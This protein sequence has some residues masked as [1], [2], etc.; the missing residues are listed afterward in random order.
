MFYIHQTSC[1]SP[2]QTFSSV[3]LDSLEEPIDK[4]MQALEPPYSDIPPGVLR[5]M[6]KVVRM[7]V[8]TAMPLLQKNKSVEGIIIGTA[9]GGKEDCVKFLNQIKEYDEGMLTPI[10][11]VQS[12]PNA[13]AAQVGLLTKNHGYNITHLHLGL[14]FEYAMIDADMLLNEKPSDNYLL[15]AVDDISTYNYYFEDKGGWYKKDSISSKDLYTSNSNGSIAG[16]GAT[17]FYVNGSSENAIATVLAVDTLHNSDLEVV[18][19]KLREFLSENLPANEQV[20][21]FLSGENGDTRVL[22][23]YETCESIAGFKDVVRFKHLC[24]EYPTATAIALWIACE[25]LNGR[26]IPDHMVKQKSGEKKMQNVLIYN[27][28]KGMQ[29]SFMLVRATK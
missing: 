18:S 12:T 4:R 25:I 7:G 21:I 9:N 28:Y 23:Y 5:R 27:T 29:H 19:K 15:G 20:D 13:V 10:N 14:A 1:I 3:N 11:F 6:G 22:K 24:G 17:M 26:T 16:E 8:G 2:Q